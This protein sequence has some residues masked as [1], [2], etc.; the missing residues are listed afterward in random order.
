M[1]KIAD[2]INLSN[3]SSSAILVSFDIGNMFPSIDNNVKIASV[4]EYLDEKEC[5]YL[6]TDCVDEALEL[7][8]SSNN[9]VVSNSNY[10]QTGGTAEG[11]HMSCS[12][13]DIAMASHD[14]KAFKLLPQSYNLK[15]FRDDI[16]AFR[17]SEQC[18]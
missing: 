18:L 7:C 8:I 2:D 5:K 17:L 15:R 16:F 11:F 13:G 14:S 3:L 9:S 1:L 10:L 4:R 6:S 12:Y